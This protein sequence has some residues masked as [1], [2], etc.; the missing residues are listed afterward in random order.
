MHIMTPLFPIDVEICV[1]ADD[2]RSVE[3]S[4]RAAGL[5]GAARIELCAAMRLQ[6]TTPAPEMIA[7][8]RSA[9]G[10]RPGLMA[11]I[12][13][14]GGDFTCSAFEIDTMLRQIDAA[15]RG[16]ADGVV[17]GVLEEDG[18]AVESLRKL[19]GAARERDLAVTFHRAFDA[20]AEP[21][22]ALDLLMELGVDRVLTSG[23]PWGDPG[24][25]V[26]GVERLRRTMLRTGSAIEVVIGGGIAPGNVGN[27]LGRLPL[28]TGR[29]SVHAYSSVLRDGLVDADTVRELVR[30]ASAIADVSR[31]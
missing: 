18:I 6:G 25:A 28:K 30:A 19:L 27:I 8:A 10:K 26:D 16:G 31:P 7:A 9:F 21:E 5:G 13:P 22:R 11:M 4:V 3:R 15:G 29:V 24:S 12:R 1:E 20:V 2:L 17:L 14:R 23:L